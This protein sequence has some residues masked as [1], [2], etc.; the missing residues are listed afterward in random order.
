MRL[1][2]RWKVGDL[3]TCCEGME[4]RLTVLE[5]SRTDVVN[6]FKSMMKQREEEEEDKK[7]LKK[8]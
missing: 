4:E 1:T 8:Y 3:A 2:S 6:E 7:T 5:A